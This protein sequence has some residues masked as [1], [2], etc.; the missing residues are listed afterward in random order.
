[1]E[2]GRWATRWA[3]LRSPEPADLRSSTLANQT[4]R[5]KNPCVRHEWSIGER[6]L[7]GVPDR[8]CL[9]RVVD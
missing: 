9:Y 6:E 2:P 5:V 3:T 7:K 8:W 4:G 1:M